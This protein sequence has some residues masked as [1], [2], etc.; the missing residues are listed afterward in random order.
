MTRSS[1]NGAH[2]GAFWPLG[3]NKKGRAGPCLFAAKKRAFTACVPLRLLLFRLRALHR[4]TVDYDFIA[5]LLALAGVGDGVWLL[6]SRESDRDER[7]YG[8]S[9]D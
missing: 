2:S 1:I 8:E 6:L 4:F 5:R 7:C 9:G 3:H